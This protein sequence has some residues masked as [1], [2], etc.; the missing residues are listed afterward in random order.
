MPPNDELCAIAKARK[1]R[2]VALHIQ[3]ISESGM[4]DPVLV[5]VDPREGKARWFAQTHC[6]LDDTRRVDAIS[7]E[8]SA[9]T[10]TPTV[11]VAFERLALAEIIPE[12]IPTVDHERSFWVIILKADTIQSVKFDFSS[13]ADR[14]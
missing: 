1:P 13:P 12:A 7:S 4:E 5:V 8:E 14:N 6:C 11:E 3:A 2:L 10:E 9:T